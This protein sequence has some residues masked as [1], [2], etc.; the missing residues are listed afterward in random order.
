V[1]QGLVAGVKV[2]K[3]PKFSSSL[4]DTRAAASLDAPEEVLLHTFLSIRS[5]H[6]LHTQNLSPLHDVGNAAGLDAH[7]KVLRGVLHLH[8]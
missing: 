2:S 4:N 5:L 8:L 3:R 6:P 7:D 1:Q